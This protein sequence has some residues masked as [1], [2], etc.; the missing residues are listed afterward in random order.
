[1][2]PSTPLLDPPGELWSTK[3]MLR[4]NYRTLFSSSQQQKGDK[5]LQQLL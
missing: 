3:D 5:P 1:M 2:V 4:N